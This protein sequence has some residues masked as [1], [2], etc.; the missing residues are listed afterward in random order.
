MNADFTVFLD[1]DGVINRK[2]PDGRFVR[3]W[4]EFEFLPGV[5]EA[6]RLLNENGIR[7]IVVTNQRGIGLGL[8]SEDDLLHLHKQMTAALRKHGAKLNGIYYCP[9]AEGACACRKP[10]IGMF[11]HAF[12]D[13]GDAAPSRSVVVGDSL[14]DMQAA[15]KLGAMKVLIGSI[16]RTM[17]AK[18]RATRIHIDFVADSLLSAVQRYILPSHDRKSSRKL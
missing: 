8:Y 10:G 5:K 3:C 1:R 11:E 17:Q 4:S 9:H 18:A 7:V 15:Q 14:S 12:R 13:F 6:V 16:D 2:L